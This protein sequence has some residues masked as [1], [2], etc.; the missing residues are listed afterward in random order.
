MRVVVVGAGPAGM[1]AAIKA[2]ENKNEVIILEHKEK[3]GKKLLATGN[4][5][6]NLTNSL[7]Q[8]EPQNAYTLYDGKE[9]EFIQKLFETYGYEDLLK[10]FSSMGLLFKNR[11]DLVYPRSDQA[12]AVQNALYS[13]LDELRCKVVTECEV[14]EINILKKQGFEVKT[15][16]GSFE[17]DRVII[18]TGSKAQPKLGADGSG[19]MLVK[20]LGH[21]VTKVAPG[22]VALKCEEKYFKDIKGVRVAANITL[23]EKNGSSLKSV[24]AESGELQLTDYGISGI[25]VMNI[26]NRVSAYTKE[27]IYKGTL[28]A[29]IDLVEE[30]PLEELKSILRKSVSTFPDRSVRGL[31]NGILPEK[32]SLQ[33]LKL[34]GIDSGWKLRRVS[35]EHIDTLVKILKDWEVRIAD[36]CGFEEA[37]ICLGGVPTLELTEKFESKIVPGIYIIGE[38]IDLHGDC[39]GFNLQLAFSEGAVA[40]S[41]IQ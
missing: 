41:S 29:Q 33:M 9:K 22:L 16:K 40:G 36:T 39:G 35:E 19:Y 5:R 28:W 8:H 17:A 23:M 30:L 38:L 20:K 12:L 26:S 25:A 7:L 1:M 37:Q 6:C 34:A 3:V 31:L 2:L 27:Q 24:Y 4:G 11:G 15:T 10:D 32:L 14:K 13:R 21:S 18:A